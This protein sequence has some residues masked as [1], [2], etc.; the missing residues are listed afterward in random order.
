[1]N[2]QR[3]RIPIVVVL[4]PRSLLLD[5]A[6]PMEV[7]RVANVVQDQVA[8]D[9]TYAA[10]SP[11]THS[12]IGLHLTGAV[13]LPAQLDDEAVVVVVG[14]A[15]RVLGELPDATADA[16]AEAS[17]IDWLRAAIRPGHLLVSICEGALLAARAGLLDGYACTT[18]H[19]C[20]A[21]L[22]KAAPPW[23]A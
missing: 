17:I 6:G 16:C 22:A 9:V 2:D 3:R 15:S 1:M 18:H 20:C 4:P 13:P 21:R 14:S 19:A 10:P 8:F 23:P 11:V 12:S 7:L 5:I